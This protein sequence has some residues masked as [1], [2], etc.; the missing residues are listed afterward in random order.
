MY[1]PEPEQT[2]G[3]FLQFQYLRDQQSSPAPHLGKQGT[4]C[5]KD[6]HLLPSYH[7]TQEGVGDGR[8]SCL[9]PGQVQA[10]G[11]QGGWVDWIELA[12]GAPPPLGE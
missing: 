4:Q 6:S 10:P 2:L 5:N 1:L 11:G 8:C 7:P 9:W 12:T 3:C